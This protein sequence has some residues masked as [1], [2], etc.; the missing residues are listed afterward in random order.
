MSVTLPAMPVTFVGDVHGWDERLARIVDQ[1]D[2]PLVFLGDLVDRGP[3]VRSVIG[4]V[5]RL[6]ESGKASC[7]LGNH[8][9]A[10]CRALGVHGPE[11]PALFSAWSSGHG[12]GGSA[13]LASYGATDAVSLRRAMGSDLD[14]LGTLPWVLEGSTHGHAWVA[15]HAGLD[16]ERP[17][18]QQVDRLAQGWQSADALHRPAELFSK[19]LVHVQPFDLPPA[20]CLVSGHTPLP[21]VLSQPQ[22]ICCDTSGGLPGRR[23]SAVCFPKRQVLTG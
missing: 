13:V 11:D 12:W 21:E 16:P 6:A 19:A 1:C 3:A 5:R 15:V 4:R 2:S 23:L 7:V 18:R 8:E 20:C 9:W 17:W 10:I 14:W 22:R